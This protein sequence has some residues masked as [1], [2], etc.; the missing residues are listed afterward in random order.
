MGRYAA[1]V[2]AK[3]RIAVPV[4]LRQALG[5][6]AIISQGYEHSLLLVGKDR[7][8][9]LTSFLTDKPLTLSP[10][11]DTE[12][13]LYG[14]AFE[15]E[16]DDQGR[17]VVPQELRDFAGLNDEAIFLGVGNRIEIW[18]R[19]NWD[20]YSKNLV[21]EIEKVAEKLT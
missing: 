21:N 7:W 8:E 13:F 10:V 3:G 5:G 14:S 4:K 19:G 17:I 11:R 6:S 1:R 18:S 15:A 12:R 16:F 2:G 20:R 9:K